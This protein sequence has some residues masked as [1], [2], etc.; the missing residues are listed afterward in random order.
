MRLFLGLLLLATM[1][2]G[3]D[4]SDPNTWLRQLPDTWAVKIVPR[5]T[6]VP[7]DGVWQ[8]GETRTDSREI[9]V[10]DGASNG[11]I[12]LHEVFHV[13]SAYGAT[14]TMLHAVEQVFPQVGAELREE[15]GAI[16]FSLQFC[17]PA[18]RKQYLAAARK[19]GCSLDSLESKRA[20]WEKVV[21]P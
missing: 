5:G 20:V 6:L 12:A 7:V 13:L 8:Q 16:L 9:I 3:A 15:T 14:K 18:D 11:V 21:R 2:V 4:L 10:E 19:A 17:S 1:A